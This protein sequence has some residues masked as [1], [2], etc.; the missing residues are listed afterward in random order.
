MEKKNTLSIETAI[1]NYALLRSLPNHTR[2]CVDKQTGKMA[3][4]ERWFSATRRYITGDSRKDLEEPMKQTFLHVYN[5]QFPTDEIIATIEMVRE[6]LILLYPK[7]GKLFDEIN[8]T[9]KL[10]QKNRTIAIEEEFGEAK[11]EEQKK[12]ENNEEQ[13]TV[14]EEFGNARRRKVSDD[15]PIDVRIDIDMDSV[16]DA[17]T[18]Y[19]PRQDCCLYELCPCLRNFVKWV[20]D[21]ISL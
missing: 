10:E 13:M 11:Q 4:E 15:A 1:T 3:L 2:L 5:A 8:E 20:K 14:Q 19:A 7:I 21:I 16:D 9:I 12:I 6:K 17:K 18:K